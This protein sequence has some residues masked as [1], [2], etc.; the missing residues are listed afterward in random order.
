MDPG[1]ESLVQI[2]RNTVPTTGALRVSLRPLSERGVGSFVGQAPG[3]SL[4]H[5]LPKRRMRIAEERNESAVS[6]ITRA[7]SDEARVHEILR[8]RRSGGIEA[9]REKRGDE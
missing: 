3:L 5:E 1:R 2:G 9:G 6:E 7:R 4:Q 8:F